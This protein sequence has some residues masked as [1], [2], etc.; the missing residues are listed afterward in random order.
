MQS[1][2]SAERAW[3]QHS[4]LSIMGSAAWR[5]TD[6]QDHG[7]IN[8]TTTLSLSP[9]PSLCRKCSP[10][11][12]QRFSRPI[13][14][15]LATGTLF[16]MQHVLTVVLVE[17]PEMNQPGWYREKAQLFLFLK[18]V[19]LS[20]CSSQG[21]MTSYI[22]TIASRKAPPPTWAVVLLSEALGILHQKEHNQERFHQSK[23]WGGGGWN[24]TPLCCP[25]TVTLEVFWLERQK[26]FLKR[27]Q[28]NYKSR[29]SNALHPLEIGTLN[30]RDNTCAC[31]NIS[32]L[33]SDK[34]SDD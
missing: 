2:W 3:S 27:D 13:S 10:V 11:S 33:I 1:Y 20:W 19:P 23:R 9:D 22:Q 14:I 29:N 30:S 4:Q 12:I 7:V 26:R 16:L 24:P 8:N 25:A 5:P 21:H 28:P 18:A 15:Q 31:G 6:I 17:A 34:R 32:R